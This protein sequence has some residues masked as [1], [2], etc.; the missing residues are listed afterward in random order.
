MAQLLHS[1]HSGLG[2]LAAYLAAHVL[3][4]LLPSFFVA[5]ALAAL[6]PKPSITRW[7]GRSTSPL[8][9]YPAA[10]SLLAVCSCTIVPLFAGIYRK[11]T[12]L[13]P[14]V[15]FLFFAPAGNILAMAYTGGVLGAQLAVARFVLCLVF[16]VGIGLLMALLFARGDATHDAQT[17]TTFAD[18]ARIGGAVLGVL[19]GLVALL[20]AGTLKLW[21]LTAVFGS[22]LLP[23][24]WT[25]AWQAQLFAW[26]PFDAARGEKCVSVQGS[27]LIALLLATGVVAW[28]GLQNIGYRENRW[29]GIALGLTAQTLVAATPR[30]GAQPD[31]LRN[32]LTGRAVAVSVAQWA[33]VL[34]ARRLDPNDLRSWLGAAWPF[35]NQ[36]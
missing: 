26:V 14:A 17:D 16:G 15:T 27:L 3:L 22:V 13:G 28:R 4:C 35:V 5:G 31:G 23:L 21:P 11:G 1:L 36:I 18:Q 32:C 34:Q 8:R 10:G 2:N 24:P 6:V 12:G 29:T 30:F 25:E 33:L 19:L 9:S 20:V 7:L